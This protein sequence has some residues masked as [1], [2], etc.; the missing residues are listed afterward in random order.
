MAETVLQTPLEFQQPV[1]CPLLWGRAFPCHPLTA[2]CCSL[3]PCCA[4]PPLHVRSCRAM[5]FLR[6]LLCTE[7]TQG[8]KLSVYILLSGLFT[9]FI[10]CLWMTSN[11]FLSFLRPDPLKLHTDLEIKLHRCT[12]HQSLAEILQQFWLIF[13][14][15]RNVF[16]LQSK[17]VVFS[18]NPVDEQTKQPVWSPKTWVGI[19]KLCFECSLSCTGM[20]ALHFDS[21]Y[22]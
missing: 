5:R 12:V 2:L 7:Q 17:A 8:P 10:V 21:W 20:S 22:Q 14:P 15:D 9:I 11:T 16:L 19:Q 4:A 6:S 18:T 3:G 1:P 13:I